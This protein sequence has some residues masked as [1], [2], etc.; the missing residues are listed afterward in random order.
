MPHGARVLSSSQFASHRWRCPSCRCAAR[1]ERACRSTSAR[2]TS[3][4]SLSGPSGTE[5]RYLVNTKHM[6]FRQTGLWQSA[7]CQKLPEPSWTCEKHDRSRGRTP[8]L[9]YL[10]AAW[11]LELWED[12]FT[13]SWASRYHHE[14]VRIIM[15]EMSYYLIKENCIHLPVDIQNRNLNVGVKTLKNSCFISS[16][17][18]TQGIL[19]ISLFYRSINQK[20]LSTGK[21][22]K[23]IFTMFFRMDD[24]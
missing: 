15:H 24:I 8:L 9:F 17:V 22:K 3:A 18:S 7:R 11:S 13:D 14:I 23:Y 2:R 4:A 12:R 21:M 10:I 20:I 6:A 1:R 16:E 19:D 5:P